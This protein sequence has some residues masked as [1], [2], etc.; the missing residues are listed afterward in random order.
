VIN[1]DTTVE[2]DE[3]FT[4]T[5][6]NASNLKL[7]TVT[8]TGIIIDDDLVPQHLDDTGITWAGE[9]YKTG[10]ACTTTET[11]EGK[12]DCHHGRDSDKTHNS[13][14]DGFAGFSFTK[15]DA[16]GKAL[17][18]TAQDHACVKDNITG[19]I[20]EVKTDSGTPRSKDKKYKWG[21]L[22]AI[23][24]DYDDSDDEL[25]K[26]EYYPDWNELVKYANDTNNAN[27]TG[28]ALCG[29][30]KWRVPNIG[31]LRSIAHLGKAKPAID[32]NYFP[33]TPSDKELYYWSSSPFGNGEAWILS[34][35]YGHDN[36]GGLKLNYN[37]LSRYS[38]PRGDSLYVRLVS[39]GQ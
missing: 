14:A 25:K 37:G 31:E 26:G 9:N 8:A 17:P 19:L 23:G 22:T 39:D 33:D 13:N 16:T 29:S 38:G 36:Y 20:W 5:L 2:S 32:E 12:Q 3:T 28:D 11:I 1:G 24:R 27:I 6:S 18:K 21:G 35:E 4:L 15:L 10:T 7:S 30:S 34:F